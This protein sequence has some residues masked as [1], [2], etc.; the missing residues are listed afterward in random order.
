VLLS[1]AIH[2][3][4]L[5]WIGQARRL[6]PLR[7]IRWP[8]GLL[9]AALFLVGTARLFISFATHP[10]VPPLALGLGVTLTSYAVYLNDRLTRG[11]RE[12]GRDRRVSSGML[13]AV[14]VLIVLSLFWGTAVY[15]AALG[16]GFAQRLASSLSV[17]PGAVVYSEE[18]LHVGGPGVLESPLPARG[19]AYR[20]RYSG[21]R[22]LIRSGG[23]YFL[24]PDD[25]STG[26]GSVIVL[27][28]DEPIRL[29]FTSG[30]E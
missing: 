3:S 30:G 22:L 14:V 24:L 25:W 9:G 12:V 28:E 8:L 26:E 16:R 19:S 29:E 15:A 11:T 4:V 6:E 7:M 13:T 2:A 1:F 17:L 23:N 18:R 20:F 21:L 27:S 5:K 10:L